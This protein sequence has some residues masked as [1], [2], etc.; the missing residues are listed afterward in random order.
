VTNNDVSL[1]GVAGLNL[2]I[3]RYY[4]NLSTDQGAFG[5]GWSMGAGADTYLEVQSDFNN[6]LDYFDGTGNA[7]LFYTDTSGN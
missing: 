2:N 7:Q 3:N 1:T 5:I 4:N 6:V